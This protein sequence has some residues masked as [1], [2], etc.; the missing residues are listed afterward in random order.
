M[1]LAGGAGMA[2]L[3]MP[4]APLRV[5]SAPAN[6]EPRRSSPLARWGATVAVADDACLVTDSSGRIVSCSA[7]AAQLLGCSVS[8]LT[9]RP[10]RQAVTFVDFE[11]GERSPAYEPRVP[12]LLAMS[13][14]TLSR[15]FVRLQVAGGQ[16][17]LDVVS[18]PLRGSDGGV[19][20]SISFIARVLPR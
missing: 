15:G 10:L 20:G 18:A 2:E 14:A 6:A 4:L 17:T 12:P 1:P 16:V 8:A 3:R 19:A 7:A 11:T 13:G 5:V 9:G